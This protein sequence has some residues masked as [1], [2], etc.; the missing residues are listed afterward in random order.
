MPDINDRAREFYDK[1]LNEDG[2]IGSVQ[3]M[4]E[5]SS[6]EREA[7][8]RKFVEKTGMVPGRD[9]RRAFREMFGKEIG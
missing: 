2:T 9:E 3:L 7:A 6:I 1:R 4:S 8:V 5:F